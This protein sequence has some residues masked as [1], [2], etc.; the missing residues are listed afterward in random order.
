MKTQ[1]NEG[2]A[3]P[4]LAGATGSAIHFIIGDRTYWVARDDRR[5]G[6]RIVA[7]G[8]MVEYASALHYGEVGAFRRIAQRLEAIENDWAH[9][10]NRP[11]SATALRG[12]T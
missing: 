4:A 10:Q 6:Y 12:Q 3:P 2:T 5:N 7:N 8:E 11:G 9:S 1:E